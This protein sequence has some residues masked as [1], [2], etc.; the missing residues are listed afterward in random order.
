LFQAKSTFIAR[1]RFWLRYL[2]KQAPEYSH[3]LEDMSP[4]G[5]CVVSGEQCQ[6]GLPRHLLAEAQQMRP[7]ILDQLKRSKLT[8]NKA[9]VIIDLSVHHLAQVSNSAVS[10]AGAI[11]SKHYLPVNQTLVFGVIYGE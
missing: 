11:L 10:S 6:L 1:E 4:P 2:T 7:G 3:A 9:P 5:G 8:V